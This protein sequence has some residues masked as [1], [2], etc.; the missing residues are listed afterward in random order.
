[1]P[2][3]LYARFFL[4]VLF[5]QPAQDAIKK[6]PITGA[7]SAFIGCFLSSYMEQPVVS[8]GKNASMDVADDQ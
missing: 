4:S 7:I 2:Q 3:I 1:M 8:E 6:G 5:R